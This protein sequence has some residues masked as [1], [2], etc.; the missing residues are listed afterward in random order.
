MT[1]LAREAAHPSTPAPRLLEL[2]DEH[3]EAV[4]RNPALT[5]LSLE[6]PEHWRELQ[7][8]IRWHRAQAALDAVWWR[9]GHVATRQ[10]LVYLALVRH[11]A[12]GILSGERR[13][14]LVDALTVW[15]R[16]FRGTPGRRERW[17]IEAY[18]TG[19]VSRARLPLCASSAGR[20]VH[21]AAELATATNGLEVGEMRSYIETAWDRHAE[22][23]HQS[24]AGVIASAL[25]AHLPLVL[26]VCRD[27]STLGRRR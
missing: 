19:L 15:E 24:A 5:L 7:D 10:R 3:P 17:R 4:A 26:A 14:Q 13:A 1:A 6:V 9:W 12:E 23:T 22:E 8:K 16:T 27:P 20:C 11:A 25:E 18:P 21:D 2:V